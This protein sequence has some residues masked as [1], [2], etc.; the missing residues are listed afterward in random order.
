MVGG[1]G[2][3]VGRGGGISVGNFDGK[4][5]FDFDSLLLNLN[6]GTELCSVLAN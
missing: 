1:G 2:I 5:L 3:S 6:I 4:S